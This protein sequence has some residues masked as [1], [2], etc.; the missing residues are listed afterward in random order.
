[1]KKHFC[2]RCKKRVYPSAW[3]PWI[4]I[5][6]FWGVLCGQCADKRDHEEFVDEERKTT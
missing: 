6:V 3:Q 5:A 1:M 4:D 2:L